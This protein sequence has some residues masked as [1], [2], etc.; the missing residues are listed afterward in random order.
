MIVGGKCRIGSQLAA[1]HS[2][3]QRHSCQYPDLLLLRL[4]KKQLRRT[5]AKTIENNLH[6]LNIGKFDG[7][8]SFLDSLDADAV[9]ANP[10]FLHQA[11]QHSENLRMVV[12]VSGR[13][14]E[15]EQIECI[16]FKV[17]QAVVNPR[18]KILVIVAVNSLLW[19]SPA[20]LC[21]YDDFVLAVLLQAS[22]KA[23][24]AA[25]AINICRVDEIHSA[26]DGLVQGLH[27]VFIGDVSPES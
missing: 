16:R 23:F 19:E 7:F 3:G 12:R 4:L 13:A 24:A 9:V 26:V 6:A 22:N 14:M 17:A 27:G 11:I 8:Q 15:L 5:L 18:G 1:Q 20:R 10:P 21:S 25:I 2:A